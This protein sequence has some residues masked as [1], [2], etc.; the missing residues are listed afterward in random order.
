MGQ[1]TKPRIA[2]VIPC[3]M[4]AAH[5]VDVIRRI[6]PEVEWIIAVDDACPENSGTVIESECRDPRVRVLRHAS[7]LGVGGAVM[8]GYRAAMSL[9]ADM[10]VKLDG[11]GQMDPALI[12]ALCAPLF[13]GRADYAKGNRFYDL[14]HTMEMPTVRLIGNAVLSFMTK[15]S[16]GYWQLFDPN[17][18][19][20]AI[21]HSLLTELN[22]DDIAKRYFFE[23]DMLFH[24]NQL[25]AVVVEIPMAARYGN[26]PSSLR[27][28]RVMGPFLRGH[29]RNGFKRIF[30]SYFLRGFSVASLEILLGFCL[31]V[32]G[33]VFGIWQWWLSFYYATSAS[34]GTVMLAALPIILGTQFILSWLGFD[35]AAEP[36]RPIHSTRDLESVLGHNRG[37]CCD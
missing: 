26:E 16:S 28:L 8:T 13:R 9:P 33:V 17:N 5:V 7:N 32:F 29:L 22:F 11:D 24:L 18:G 19:F 34:A 27:P 36:K 14:R 2:V 10:V 12:P 30:Y 21:H 1:S 37:G 6:G 35:V 23:S 15:Y 25:R 3:Y 31:C 4:V 20:T